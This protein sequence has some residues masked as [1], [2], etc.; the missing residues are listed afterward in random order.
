MPS[1]IPKIYDK[2]RT[3]KYEKTSK[4]KPIKAEVIFALADLSFSASP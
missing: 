1:P 3:I 4:I 2:R